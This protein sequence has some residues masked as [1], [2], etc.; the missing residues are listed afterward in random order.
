MVTRRP[1]VMPIRISP[2]S[3]L[4]RYRGI[5]TKR[6]AGRYTVCISRR[7]LTGVIIAR[8][9]RA[10]HSAGC[11]LLTARVGGDLRPPSAAPLL[12][13]ISAGVPRRTFS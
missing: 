8:L 2:T 10:A 5:Q 3:T 12:P 9:A 4:R 7:A 1:D 6:Y 13:S 11:M